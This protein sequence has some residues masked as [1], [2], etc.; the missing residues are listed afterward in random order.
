MSEQVIKIQ[1]QQGFSE[2][3]APG[4][5]IRKLVDFIIPGGGGNS[6][7]LSKSY[8]NINVELANLNI[9][10][11]LAAPAG[12][13]SSDTALFN[14]DIVCKGGLVSSDGDT[15]INAQNT[16]LVR[17]A[18]MFSASRG[19]VESIRRVDTLRYLLYDL[20]NSKTQKNVNLN[21]LGP[22]T[23]AR[24]QS[25]MTS[26]MIQA[27]PINVDVNGVADTS[28]TSR[29][30]TRDIQ[31]PISDIFGVGNAVWN[32][33]VYGDTRI[34][35]ELNMNRLD[36][37]SLGT[38]EDTE[39]G[40]EALGGF[41]F[42]A[43]DDVGTAAVPIAAGTEIKSF[44]LELLYSDP[45]FMMP[46][47]VG[48]AV[49][50]DFEENIEV[51]PITDPKTYDP[52]ND[53][54]VVVI[55]ESIQ[56]SVGA[57]TLA[58]DPRCNVTFRTPIYTVQPAAAAYLSGITMRA[59]NCEL[60]DPALRAQIRVNKAEI[61]LTQVETPGPSQID[62]TTYSTE[63]V[64]GNNLQS[65]NRQYIV[66]P[67][68]QNLIVATVPAGH[69]EPTQDWTDYQIAINNE[70]QTGNRPVYYHRNLHQ[71]RILRFMNNRGQ[72]TE[73]LR[74]EGRR[75]NDADIE[76]VNAHFIITET[77]PITQGTKAVDLEI[78]SQN[79]MQDI[80]AYKELIRS[81]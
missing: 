75:V 4:S 45:G 14:T 71:D 62:Y 66:E 53:I 79:G 51:T 15:A 77:L 32:G 68:A 63:E 73:S 24:Q 2:Q 23:G 33:A 20:E 11:G 80:I 35:M 37:I 38:A 54:G 65:F 58:G 49:L 44:D 48:Q 9:A 27:I 52:P 10:S 18:S 30:I 19:M 41:S 72:T 16:V 6:Y 57:N 36:L 22:V 64:Q 46:F 29:A 43:A 39:D 56:W 55:I 40:P 3:A 60:V 5:F 69:T 13:L 8:I 26:S 74:L 70:N 59:A 50:V 67:N 47:Y 34:H 76:S 42:G 17:N 78:N 1:S 28:L 81:I 61:V 12:I 31:I 21:Q 25:N 7:D